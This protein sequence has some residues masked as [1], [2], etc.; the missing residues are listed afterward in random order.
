MAEP[1]SPDDIL[2]RI[3]Q[4]PPF[5]FVDQIEELD[6]EHAVGVYR[7]REDEGFYAGHF[8][9]NPVTPGVILIE[10]MAQCGVVPIALHLFRTELAQAE[11]DKLQTLFTDANVEFSGIVRPGQRVRTESRRI[12]YRRR[13]LRVA[14]EMRIE[15]GTLVCS[16]ELSGMGVL[17]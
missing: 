5:R 6:G 13:K 17:A 10:C 4:Q 2:A 16:G 1:L 9:G 12:F 3:P 11:A 14:A 7:F 15:D 8:P